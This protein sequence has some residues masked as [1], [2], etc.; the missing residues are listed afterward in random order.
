M[1]CNIL[2]ALTVFAAAPQITPL[3]NLLAA[4]ETAYQQWADDHPAQATRTL[5]AA[6]HQAALELQ[7]A[8]AAS[9]PQSSQD[10]AQL[11][12]LSD[13]L[14][15]ALALYRRYSSEL[16]NQ[17][18]RRELLQ[19]VEI[20]PQFGAAYARLA[21]M[22]TD[23]AERLG[24]LQQ[25]Q[26][27]G[28][29]DN[30][31]GA[32]MATALPPEEQPDPQQLYSGKV[33]EVQWR[34]LPSIPNNEGVLRLQPLLHPSAQAAAMARTWVQSEE[35]Q[36]VLLYLGFSSEI[37]VWLNGE[38]VFDAFGPHDFRHDSFAVPVSLRK[39]WNELT[40][41]LG[42]RSRGAQWTA[43]FAALQSG[44]PLH[45]LH[46][47]EL[48][49]E[50]QAQ[51]LS[52][53]PAPAYDLKADACSQVPGLRF[54]LARAD[55]HDVARAWFR[56]SVLQEIDQ[57][58]PRHLH[59]GRQAAARAAKLAPQQIRYRL[60][61]ARSLSQHQEL[62]AEKDVNPWLRELNATLDLDP[63]LPRAL[64]HKARHASRN[65]PTFSR[66]IELLERAA[67]RDGLSV[68]ARMMRAQVLSF[69][70]QDALATFEMRQLMQQPN[71]YD[72]PRV[73]LHALDSLSNAE[74]LFRH[75]EHIVAAH[76][77]PSAIEKYSRLAQLREADVN[78]LQIQLQ[79]HRRW[80]A[81]GLNWR[82]ELAMN[83]LSAG[84]L[85]AAMEL[86]QEALLLAPEDA[87]VYK[88]MARAHLLAGR[89]EA[90][91]EALET[92]LSLDF[93]AEDERRLL[94]HLRNQGAAPFHV[95]YQEPLPQ[96]LKRSAALKLAQPELAAAAAES[97]F[98]TLLKR[99]VVR[100]HPDGTA[101]RYHRL[102][103][104]V[105]NERGVRDLD[106]V[107]F[108]AAPGDQE[109]RILSAVVQHADGK[110]SDAPTSRGGRRGGAGVDLPPLATG[111]I[112]DVEYRLDDLRTT[113]FGNYFSL[114]E[115]FADS[116]STPTLESE[117]VLVVPED[118]TLALHQ[119]GFDDAA[120]INVLADGSRRYI[121]RQTGLRAI[122]IEAG[123]PPPTEFIPI[124]QASSYANWQDFATWWWDLI[125]DEIRVSADMKSKVLELTAQ[126]KTAQQKLTAI[127]NFVVTDIR[128]NAWEF[129]VH[130]YQPYSAPIIF[131][132]GFGDC[133]DK[134]ILLRA[135][136]SEVGIEAY[137]VL[138]RSSGRRFEEDLTLAMVSHFNHCI[139]YVPSQAGLEEQ[140]LDGTA[141]LHTI[142]TLPESDQGAQVLIVKPDSSERR[143]IPFATAEQNQLEHNI[144]VQLNHKDGPV[145]RYTRAARGRFDAQTRHGFTGST[146]EQ[147]ENAE[148]VITSLF[149]PL[150]GDLELIDWPD[151]E[152]L[153]TPLSMTFL[154]KPTTI[155]RIGDTGLELPATFDKLNL[156]QSV[157]SE[158][159]RKTDLLMGSAWSQSSQIQFVLPP[160]SQAE[161]LA[162]VDLKSEFLDYQRSCESSDG[163]VTIRETFAQKKHRIPASEYNA[164]RDVCRQI[165]NA[166]NQDLHIHLQ[167]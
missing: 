69:M 1:L 60:Q 104:R 41:K 162:A 87:G 138:I 156:L 62:A 26:F 111:D 99:V 85:D 84:Q 28:P 83:M 82:K 20:S 16:S 142:A 51:P 130:G 167:P 9:N 24:M 61:H 144:E 149:G 120:E 152:D 105:L 132:R 14:E 97:S 5:A 145:V 88:V 147:I 158:T 118:F 40:L 154:A 137:P 48:P 127:Y 36:S 8:Q 114:N 10:V 140:F 45:L 109:V 101:H 135:M 160:N 80:S 58:M 57:P 2:L 112:V 121:W 150:R 153:N 34:Q 89:P 92:E 25:W 148:A 72:Y 102:V 15:F 139:A 30:E 56:R 126:A 21:W 59:P 108:Y 95:A 110:R 42:G 117:I 78:P 79:Q 81:W 125:E 13:E 11:S 76:Y 165:D 116:I 115:T 157:G 161:L 166:Q 128:Y 141:R 6:I 3:D 46:V 29:F 77:F 67:E 49:P 50:T 113:F 131:S 100:V 159:D 43:R 55:D 12:T 27:V 32:A 38:A 35:A 122:E 53:T 70:D 68:L 94:Q 124:V 123:M 93:S 155:G 98:E 86:L 90:A 52:A 106:T 103:R 63:G 7:K 37:R 151:F 18:L 4:E 73:M 143:L 65:Q 96:I 146:E 22:R 17:S 33:R 107:G 164:F 133:K 71:I 136:L 47:S 19:G 134:A 163:V 119:R 23:A 31:R 74:Q 66:A 44:A 54:K 64:R 129:G 39:G 75:Y 91:V